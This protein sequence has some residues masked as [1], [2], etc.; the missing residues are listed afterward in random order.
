MNTGTLDSSETA[1]SPT[2]GIATASTREFSVPT[3]RLSRFLTPGDRDW[4]D[5]GAGTWIAGYAGG[6]TYTLTADSADT[7]LTLHNRGRSDLAVLSIPGFTAMSGARLTPLSAGSSAALPDNEFHVLQAERRGGRP[8]VVG[9]IV[10]DGVPAFLIHPPR[11]DEVD[12]PRMPGADEF[13]TPYS[14]TPHSAAE[15]RSASDFH[16][17]ADAGVFCESVA[18]MAVVHN[19]GPRRIAV[20]MTGLGGAFDL[21]VALP[22]ESIPIP[23]GPGI[24]YVQAARDSGRPVVVDVI[25]VRP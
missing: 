2:V 24:H 15:P 5:D 22:G 13:W 10:D 12:W 9:Q 21:V 17:A 23:P 8:V 4:N 18:G 1:S 7:R 14:A 16:D 6:L 19:R 25:H 3:G 20:L 11:P